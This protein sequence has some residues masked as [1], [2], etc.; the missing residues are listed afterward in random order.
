MIEDII[1]QISEA[2]KDVMTKKAE[3][4][5]IETNFVQ[6]KSKLT[7]P[8]FVQTLVF[9]WQSNPDATL[10]ELSQTA[11][12]LGLEITPQGLND[13]FSERSA[14]FLKKLLSEAIEKTIVS[15]PVDIDLLKRFNG[16]YI[17]DSSVIRLP[18]KLSDYWRG[19]GGSNPDGLRASVKL[20]VR[21]NFSVGRL[22][23]P[24][25]QDGRESDINS[26]YQT[27]L[28]P[29]KALK[30]IDMGYFKLEV[31]KNWSDN[32]V[33]WLTRLKTNTKIYNKKGKALDLIKLLK[34]KKSSQIDMNIKLGKK[35]QLPCRLLALAIPE[36]VANK[37]RR[38][39]RKEGKREGIT[40]TKMR[41]QMASWNIF[42]T[43]IPAELVTFQEALILVRVRWQIELLFKLWKSHGKIDE[44]RTENEWR[45]LSELYA[46]LLVM[47]IQHW[48]ILTSLWKYPDKSWTKA[49][50]TIQRFALHLASSF[51][52]LIRLK[53]AISDI[54]I[55]LNA[56]CRIT[57][58]KKEPAT[59]QLLLSPLKGESLA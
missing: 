26:P 45:I 19:C 7:G 58:R 20:Q 39:I 5:S 4:F 44:W 50:K 2:M 52:S 30:L 21:L 53:K 27:S 40:P 56:G 8:L 46:K 13:R 32:E 6:R 15:E 31:L 42:I 51:Y 17:E 10:D 37:R 47:I 57:K 48:L 36:E 54:Q 29:K 22:Y 55:C 35:C 24:I 43:N 38:K 11:S 12:I 28:L 33:F 9:G 3:E 25:L 1:S 14:L 41:L 16:V 18:D 23:G 59:F 34:D 49:A